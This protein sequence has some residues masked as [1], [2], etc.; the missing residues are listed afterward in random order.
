MRS[1]P[2]SSVPVQYLRCTRHFIVVRLFLLDCQSRQMRAQAPLRTRCQWP[3][4]NRRPG[5]LAG[6]CTLPVAVILC[7]NVLLTLAPLH[8]SLPR[9]KHSKN[10]QLVKHVLVGLR[11]ELPPS[12]RSLRQGR[13]A[14]LS[15]SCFK[16]STHKAYSSSRKA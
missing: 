5:N 13:E 14:E 11:L 6:V 12:Q 7:R 4:A 15:P 9:F 16:F 1:S 2:S 8:D 3:T 10:P